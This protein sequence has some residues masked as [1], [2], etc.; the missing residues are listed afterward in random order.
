MALRPLDDQP[1][2]RIARRASA[3]RGVVEPGSPR[4]PRPS[5]DDG[6]QESDLERFS[7]V[8]V[9]C[10]Q[11]GAELYDDA[12]VCYRCGSAVTGWSDR[13]RRVW[14][15]VIVVLLILALLV[16]ATIGVMR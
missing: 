4:T 16:A 6:P 3:A 5:S 9:R 11:C 2:Q 1:D 12:E 10:P 14:P 13:E 8:T 15:A 7:G